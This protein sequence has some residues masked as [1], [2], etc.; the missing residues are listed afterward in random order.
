MLSG[1]MGRLATFHST[2]MKAA[3]E[4]PPMV[5]MEMTMGEDH[6]KY[7]PPPESGIRISTI[8][9][10]AVIIPPQSMSLNCCFAL[11]FGMVD[12]R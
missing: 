4:R 9:I 7:E 12:G 10:V 6:S 3:N 8:A 11:P 1:I 5:S 2:N